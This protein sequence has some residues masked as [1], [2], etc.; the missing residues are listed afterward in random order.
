MLWPGEEGMTLRA[1]WETDAE[2]G[3]TEAL[4]PRMTS[5]H[6]RPIEPKA[7]WGCRRVVRAWRSDPGVR[8]GH[9]VMQAKHAPPS[10]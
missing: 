2:P 7:E 6:T 10:S 1:G 3:F 4:R 9:A 5:A 8:E